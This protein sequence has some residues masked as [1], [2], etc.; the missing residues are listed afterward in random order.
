MT[1]LNKIEKIKGFDNYYSLVNPELISQGFTRLVISGSIEWR[2][3]SLKEYKDLT[4]WIAECYGFRSVYE[5]LNAY[6]DT[7]SEK[8]EQAVKYTKETYIIHLV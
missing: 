5:I 3:T 6:N 1:N 4:T 8:H 2:I 7:A